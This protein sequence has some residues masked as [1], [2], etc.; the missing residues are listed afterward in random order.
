[1]GPTVA[2]S[3]SS[4][5]LVKIGKWTASP[6]RKRPKIEIGTAKRDRGNPTTKLATR[7]DALDH[8]GRGATVRVSSGSVGSASMGEGDRRGDRVGAGRSARRGRSAGS[9]LERREPRMT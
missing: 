2:S 9:V 8:D 7:P 4:T 1:M 3:T 5:G 6:N